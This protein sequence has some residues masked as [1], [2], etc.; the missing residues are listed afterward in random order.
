MDTA[1]FYPSQKIRLRL[2]AIITAFDLLSGQGEALNIDLGD[3]INA[4]FALLRPLCLDTGLEDPPEGSI[5]S[6]LNAPTSELMFQ[7]LDTIFFS[8]TN[9]TLLPPWRLAAFAKRLIECALHFPSK[10]AKR[11]LEMVRTM[12]VKEP[13]LEGMLDSEERM[14]DGV[15]RPELDDPQLMNPFATSMWEIEVLAKEHWDEGV[16]AE[17]KHL[18]EG[19][20]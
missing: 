10:S 9:R 1:E 2:V 19:K 17:V 8:H 3:F 12:M 5:P 18:R 15:Y 6:R 11:A 4:L 20:L 14:F 7:C 16:R 13:K